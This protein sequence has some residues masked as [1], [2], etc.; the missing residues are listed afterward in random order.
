MAAR[1]IDDHSF[2]AGSGSK[3]SVLPESAKCKSMEQVE[4]DG[5]VMESRETEA[6]IARDQRKGVSKMRSHDMKSGYRY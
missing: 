1:R 4:G 3:N 6:D 2:W 5:G